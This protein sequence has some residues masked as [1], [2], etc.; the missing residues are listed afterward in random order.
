MRSDSG[1]RYRPAGTIV[2]AVSGAVAYIVVLHASMWS[3]VVGSGIIR[4]LYYWRHESSGKA[5]DV[6]I[7]VI[8]PSL[9]AGMVCGVRKA[10]RHSAADAPIVVGMAATVVSAG[11]LAMSLFNTFPNWHPEVREVSLVRHWMWDVAVS[12]ACIGLLYFGKRSGPAACEASSGQG[13]WEGQ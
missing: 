13:P 3:E 1:T 9:L 5:L 7:N 2:L 6:L 4:S 11:Y 12:C 8:M 10:R